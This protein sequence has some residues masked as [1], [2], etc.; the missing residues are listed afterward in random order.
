LRLFHTEMGLVLERSV[1]VSS[2]ISPGVFEFTVEKPG[3]IAAGVLLAVEG[4]RD[5]LG[6]L[7]V[8]G[9]AYGGPKAY[10]GTLEDVGTGEKRLV[11]VAMLPDDSLK[12]ASLRVDSVDLGGLRAHFVRREVRS[13][14]MFSEDLD[15][16]TV[17]AFRGAPLAF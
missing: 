3:E 1:E 16:G 13:D 11:L 12:S 10:V 7:D 8:V 5:L 14:V 4:M 6:G 17:V 15:P 2:R 9:V